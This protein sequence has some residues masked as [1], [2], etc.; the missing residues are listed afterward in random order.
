MNLTP[1]ERAALDWFAIHS[2]SEELKRQ[3]KS[4]VVAARKHTGPGQVTIFW[5]GGEA[6]AGDFATNCV[7]NAPLVYSP[8]L[9]YG[10]SVDLWLEKGRIREMEIVAL[11]DAE[12]PKEAFPFAL[13]DAL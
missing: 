5:C 9:P 12:L 10:A 13:V 4:A 1:L 8:V 6:P 3:C 2:G 11:G 7:P